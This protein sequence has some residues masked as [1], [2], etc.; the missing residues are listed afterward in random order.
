M[1]T[2]PQIKDVLEA[3]SIATATHFNVVINLFSTTWSASYVRLVELE[4]DDIFSIPL[5]AAYALWNDPSIPEYPPE[6]WLLNTSLQ[7][8]NISVAREI[9][10]NA[11]SDLERSDDE[12]G[13]LLNR[14]RSLLEIDAENIFELVGIPGGPRPSAP[15]RFGPT[16]QVMWQTKCRYFFLEV[17]NES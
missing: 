2:A 3:K 17:H 11:I 15:R 10:S 16:H 8:Q 1:L 4:T 13:M 12:E 9:V 6:D 7:P 14:L 5:L